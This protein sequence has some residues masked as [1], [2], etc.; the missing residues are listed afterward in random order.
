MMK[1]WEPGA[2]KTRLGATIG[3]P[4]SAQLHQAFVRHLCGQLAKSATD[5]ELVISPP[6]RIAD[7]ERALKNWHIHSWGTRVQSSGDL[8]DRMAT[9]FKESLEESRSAILIGADC[10]QLSHQTIAT[11]TSLLQNH[12]VVLGPAAD[13]GY[14]LIGLRGSVLRQN[15][16]DHI[17][18]LFENMTWSQADV[19]EITCQRISELGMSLSLLSACEDIDTVSELT[20][21]RTQLALSEM[22][23]DQTLRDEVEAILPPFP[24]TASLSPP[25]NPE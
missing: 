1:Y 18:R 7:I 22:V 19:F 17:Q 24:S 5:R 20:R 16:Q 12:D 4:V 8:G 2:V 15:S 10:P 13:G 25:I 21:L 23:A 11:A 3:M 14:Y 9:W 6:E